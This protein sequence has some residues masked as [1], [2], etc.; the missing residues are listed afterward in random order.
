MGVAWVVV[1]VV[2]VWVCMWAG[3]AEAL[4]A[5]PF[6]AFFIFGDSLVD[7]GNNNYIVSVARANQLPFGI[8]FPTGPTG[9][10]CNGK[11]VLDIIA[12]RISLPYP[13]PYLN[14][15]TKGNALLQGVSYASGAAGILRS[16]GF[17][18]IGRVDFDT[19]IDW[20]ENN[21]KELQQMLGESATRDLLAKSLY[22][23]VFGSNDYVNNYLLS[24]APVNK[25]YT[26]DQFKL[27][28][29]NKTVD[30]LTRIYNLGAR[31]IA[32]SGIGPIGCIPSQLVR[33]RSV[34]G[35]CS[36]YVNGLAEDFNEGLKGVIAQLNEQLPGATIVYADTYNNVISYVNSPAKY[37]FKFTSQACCGR[38]KY[39]GQ[40][41][42]L[43][44]VTPCPDRADYVFWDAFHPTE[45]ANRLLGQALFEDLSKFIS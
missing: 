41:L 19:Q 37:G 45:A 11:T 20:F 39:K 38:G 29:L 42:C 13:P 4:S 23:T 22:A 18:F 30:Q 6:P 2:S 24:Y 3:A 16:S 33:Q 14:P 36:D 10:F 44:V 25:I 8:D 35:E 43:P 21:V 31:L 5:K 27:V 17:N 28:V 7:V 12:E 34:N 9:R 40:L 1:V 26:T 32:V 15:A